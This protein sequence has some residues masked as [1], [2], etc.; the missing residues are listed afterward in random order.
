MMGALVTPFLRG[1]RETWGID[2]AAAS[3]AFPG[4]ELVPAPS[5]GWTH[6]VEIDA[7]VAEVWPWVA[8]IGADSVTS[9]TAM[10][11]MEGSDMGRMTSEPRP[12]ASR[13]GR[14]PKTVVAV[15]ISAGRMRLL[16][17]SM[18]ISRTCARERGRR[19]S[20]IWPR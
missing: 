11:P 13:T 7:P 1:S 12:S 5:W 15:V 17:A 9:W 8:Q 14:R 10:P 19:S 2:P 16:A 4:D 18:T 20:N 6:A 3:R